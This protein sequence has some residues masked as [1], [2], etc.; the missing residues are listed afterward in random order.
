MTDPR[1]IITAVGL[2]AAL[3][4]TMVAT[5]ASATTTEALTVRYDV[6]LGG[7]HGL[8]AEF[9]LRRSA[10]RYAFESVSQTHGF[11]SYLFRW[12][13]RSMG[14]GRIE[15]GRFVPAVHRARSVGGGEPRGLDLLYD[16]EGN[17][18][19]VAIEPKSEETDRVPVPQALIRGAMDATTGLIQALGTMP[20]GGACGGTIPVYDGRRRFDV[21]LAPQGTT[22][23]APNR[24]SSFAGPASVC[25][26]TF[27][28]VAGGRTPERTAFWRRIDAEGNAGFPTLVYLAPVAPGAEMMP[29]RVE[30][31]SPFGW[32]IVHIKGVQAARTT[33][34]RP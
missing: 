15:D 17:V 27:R 20:P 22:D 31:D 9:T 14:E 4:A 25:R 29:V 12:E 30:V 18:S 16:A 28:N 33:A 21:R 26:L 3:S 1:R 19:S 2:A 5:A 34:E 10:G 24:Y 23:L 8:D 11:W 13:S 32:A 7:I 6:Y